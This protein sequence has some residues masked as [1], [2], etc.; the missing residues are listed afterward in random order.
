MSQVAEEVASKGANIVPHTKKSLVEKF[1]NRFGVESNK[2]LGTL[3]ATAFK[4]REGEVTNEQMMAL[5]VVADQYG[6]NPFTKE[7]YAFPDKQNGVVPIV[8]LDGWSRI[9]NSHPEFDG[10]EFVSSENIITELTDAKSCPEWIECVIYRKDRE[11]PIRVREYLDE[12]YRPPFEK[13]GYK[14]KGPW[15]THTKRMLRH[16]SMI[17]GSRIAFGFVGIYDQDE[18]ERIIEAEVVVEHEPSSATADLNSNL[19]AAPVDKSKA[20]AVY[21]QEEVPPKETT[22]APTE[23]DIIHMIDAAEDVDAVM[24]A[25]DMSNSIKLSKTKKDK[26]EKMVDDKINALEGAAE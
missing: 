16:K 20:E 13:N 15:Q 9:I 14:V 1:A 4:Q 17:Q 23:A 25:L 5:L 18:A 24:A 19:G 11:H 12:V 8:G 21:E 3:K 6:L 22:E 10:M 7:I 26:L 2:M